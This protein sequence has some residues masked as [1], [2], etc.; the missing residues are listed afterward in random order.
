MKNSLLL[1]LLASATMLVGCNKAPEAPKYTEEDIAL[2]QVFVS[3]DLGEKASLTVA[4]PTIA[5]QAKWT[6]SNESVATVAFGEV[7][8]LSV[9]SVVI[10]ASY[11]KLTATCEVE[12][13]NSYATP[14]IEFSVSSLE[15]AIGDTYDVSV[16]T[17]YRGETIV[18][19][20]YVWNSND[21][22]IA[23]VERKD[24]GAT[25][26]AFG[27]GTTNISVTYSCVAGEF[28]ATLPVTVYE[29][30]VVFDVSNA[31]PA[32]GGYEVDVTLGNTYSPDVKVYV[33]GVLMNS[34]LIV[35][36]IEDVSIVS[37]DGT[38]FNTLKKGTTTIYGNYKN[39]STFSI[40]VNL[41]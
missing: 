1:V 26:V 33:D 7:S 36:S 15:L 14:H 3:L 9:G 40:K 2:N 29:N 16:S 41:K 28:I 17:Q 24:E 11:G 31:T 18:D 22:S 38:T 23:F 34:S 39:I 21:E 27:A 20:E 8:A 37:Y 12:V 5:K 6:S 10:T 13:Y 30:V 25:I 32:K 19:A 35:W 4:N